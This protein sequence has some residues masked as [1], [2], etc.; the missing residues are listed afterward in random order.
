MSVSVKWLAVKTASEMTYTVSSGA[1]NS[2]PT[3]TV[4]WRCRL[5]QLTCIMSVKRV[6][7]GWDLSEYITYTSLCCIVSQQFRC[8]LSRYCQLL[9][10][11]FQNSALC[12][13]QQFC[14]MYNNSYFYIESINGTCVVITCDKQHYVFLLYNSPYFRCP[15]YSMRCRV[16]ATVGCP[17]VCLSIMSMG[18][19]TPARGDQKV[20]QLPIIIN[21]MVKIDGWVGTSKY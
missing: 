8:S 5:T 7:V 1:L 4:S 20:L 6:I 13:M 12:C 17:S 9:C 3:T 16:C 21:K 18:V 14:V 11:L 10:Y 15:H 2:T 19:W